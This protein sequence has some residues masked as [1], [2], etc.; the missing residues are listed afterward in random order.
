MQ[1]ITLVAAT[2]AAFLAVS[3][4]AS[5]CRTRGAEG[6]SGQV[7]ATSMSLEQGKSCLFRHFTT[8]S[9][10]IGNRRFPTSDIQ[11]TGR[12]SQGS[13]E[14]SG[15]RVIYKARA[16]F[17]GGDSFSYRTRIKSGK[18]FDYRVAVDIY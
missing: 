9:D 13:V 4:P 15:N 10:S 3:T 17:R 7:V 14:I 8:T 2:A 6:V 1:R 18:Q 5:A 16:G 12:P 11:V